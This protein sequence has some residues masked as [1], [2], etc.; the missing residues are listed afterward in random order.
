MHAIAVGC[1]DQGLVIFVKKE[2]GSAGNN[3]CDVIFEFVL[4]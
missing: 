2:K 3:F 4:N 1:Q